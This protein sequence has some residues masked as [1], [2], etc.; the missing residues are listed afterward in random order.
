[1]A[2]EILAKGASF[3]ELVA[4]T[5][6]L[7]QV[8]VVEFDEC[9]Y[10][11]KTLSASDRATLT[12]AVKHRVDWLVADERLLRRV[13]GEEGLQTIGTLGLLTLAVRKGVLSATEARAD[14]DHAVS[15]LGFRISSQLYQRVIAELGE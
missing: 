8:E 6:F 4:L 1:V 2:D 11:S 10:E 5:A 13:A 3:R 12:F 14:L 9:A 15:S 7:S